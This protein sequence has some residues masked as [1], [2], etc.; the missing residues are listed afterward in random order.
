MHSVQR[1]KFCTSAD[2]VLIVTSTPANEYIHQ[3]SHVVII[4]RVGKK[5]PVTVVSRAKRKY[6]DQQ[7]IVT[8]ETLH[9]LRKYMYT[10]TALMKS[11][12]LRRTF[13]LQKYQTKYN[14][15][16]RATTEVLDLASQYCCNLFFN[17]PRDRCH[18]NLLMHNINGM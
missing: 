1:L 18:E 15:L 7:Q 4:Q 12:I 13:E 8:I 6:K 2:D 14:S 16:H 11:S 10:C 5:K 17:I 3:I 9:E